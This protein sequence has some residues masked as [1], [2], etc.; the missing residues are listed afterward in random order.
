MIRQTILCFLCLFIVISLNAQNSPL[1]S[2]PV[3]YEKAVDE[4][5][6]EIQGLKKK[7]PKPLKTIDDANIRNENTDSTF[8]VSLYYEKDAELVSN[9]NYR[10]GMKSPREIVKYGE[11]GLGLYIYFIKD[12]WTGQQ[13]AI[14][15]EFGE[16]NIIMF[17]YN[18]NFGIEG[19]IKKIIEN[20]KKQ[21]GLD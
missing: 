4:M 12:D 19:E 11:Y 14:P 3:D 17:I 21:L 5:L 9:P 7:F 6:K 2:G 15:I 1:L 10:E 8:N 13:L 18:D 20:K 16:L